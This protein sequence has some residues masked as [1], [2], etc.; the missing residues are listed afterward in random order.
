MQDKPQPRK[1]Q[2]QVAVGLDEIKLEDL[3][4]EPADPGARM[5][6]TLRTNVPPTIIKPKSV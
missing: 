4:R 5:R 6:D 3:I 2:V 1:L